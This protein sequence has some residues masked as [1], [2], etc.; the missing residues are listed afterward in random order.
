VSWGRT[1]I[2]RTTAAESA[3]WTAKQALHKQPSLF[4]RST[5]ASNRRIRRCH[6]CITGTEMCRPLETSWILLTDAYLHRNQVLHI[7]SGTTSHLRCNQILPTHA[8]RQRF[9]NKNDHKPLVYAFT[10]K[11]DKANQDVSDNLTTSL[12]SVRR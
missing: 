11:L 2:P 10:Q 3:L 1:T 4:H 5:R 12:N 8:T 7:R 9:R 6:W